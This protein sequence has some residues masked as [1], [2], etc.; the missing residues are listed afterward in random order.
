LGALLPRN[1]QPEQEYQAGSKALSSACDQEGREDRTASERG[2]KKHRAETK[3]AL[4]AVEKNSSLVNATRVG[5]QKWSRTRQIRLA[6]RD[7]MRK[8]IQAAGK[9]HEEIE[10][11]I[12]LR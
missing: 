2:E 3:G 6:P 10:A 1:G 7:E 9:L 4:W 5:K 12:V 8:M 11:K